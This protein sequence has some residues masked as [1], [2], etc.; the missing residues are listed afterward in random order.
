M[1]KDY[2]AWGICGDGRN[3][4]KALNEANDCLAK[5]RRAT[6]ADQRDLYRS[7]ISFAGRGQYAWEWI[8]K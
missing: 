1:K 6:P 3:L 5:A 4:G 8:L 7:R 2:Q